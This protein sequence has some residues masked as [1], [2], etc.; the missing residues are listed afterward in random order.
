MVTSHPPNRRIGA[1]K[2]PGI[3]A[4]H[5]SSG[6]VVRL[7]H[8]SARY[9]PDAH[10]IGETKGN[11]AWQRTL[12]LVM[13]PTIEENFILQQGFD[14]PTRDGLALRYS[15]LLLQPRIV[16]TAVAVGIVL[17]SPWV[18]LVLSA[19]LWWS[20]LLPRLNPFDIAYNL[21]LSDR[22]G[23][24]RLTPAPAPR[25]F[26]Q[27]MAGTFALAIGA[28]LLAGARTPAYA[29]EAFF[30]A[31]AASVALGG[32]CVGSFVYH[33]LRGETAFATRTLPWARPSR[34]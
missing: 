1:G 4:I 11:T 32:F 20:A 25:R 7:P 22:G 6:T 18:F 27:G 12:I 21:L 28:A 15:A 13:R 19:I 34:P 24:P 10:A 30:L 8:S 17:Q 26:S 31:A 16:G 3:G 2:F 14:G 33:V 9:V 29:L 23:R 5:A